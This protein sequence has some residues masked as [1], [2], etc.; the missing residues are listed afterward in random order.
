MTTGS[1][2]KWNDC[3]TIDTSTVENVSPDGLN[4]SGDICALKCADGFTPKA[5]KKAKCIQEDSEWSWNKN[6][7]TCVTCKDI[8]GIE[9]ENVQVSCKINA[10][11]FCGNTAILS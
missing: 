6:L 3:V 10:S 4:C 11:K 9:D 5:P 2:G 8:T 7:G 1:H